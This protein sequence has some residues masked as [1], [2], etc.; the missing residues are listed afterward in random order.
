GCPP[1]LEYL[2]QIDQVLIQQAVALMEAIIGIECKTQFQ[3]MNSMGQQIFMAAEESGFWSR[4]CC[5]QGRGFKI[6]ITDNSAK[7]VMTVSHGFRCCIGCCWCAGCSNHCAYDVTIEA[8]PGNV[9]GY[10]KQ[11]YS[12][13]S[14]VYTVLDVNREP[15]LVIK[16]PC[17]ICSCPCFDVEFN[18]FNNAGD[19]LG[20]IS[21]QWSGLAKELFTNAQN[22]GVSFPLDMEP[23]T[24]ALLMG[25][26]FLIVSLPQELVIYR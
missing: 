4:Q 20:M 6:H 22:M 3:I 9:I 10:V 12:L 14:P 13:W 5:Q 18:V 11:A 8:P 1:G 23:M 24:K 17:C 15:V 19:Q 26:T 21:K 25:A 7:E 2:T 16:G